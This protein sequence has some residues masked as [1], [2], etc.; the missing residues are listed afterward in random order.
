[1]AVRLGQ[2]ELRLTCCA[3]AVLG[4]LACA[5]E[6][7]SRAKPDTRRPPP[8]AVSAP[9]TSLWV[10]HEGETLA[11]LAR[12]SGASTGELARSNGIVD[13]NLII[14]GE[15]LR[16]P[17]GHH[18]EAR[19]AP[20]AAAPSHS[21]ARALLSQANASLEA[22]DFE[23]AS[24]LAARCVERLGG[25]PVEAKA[26]GLAARCHLVAGT[27]ATGLDRRDEAVEEFRR[28]LALDPNLELAP[29]STS[30]RVRELLEVARTSPLPEQP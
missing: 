12:C 10:V 25:A 5:S 22:A 14:A 29:D 24:A 21:A 20:A 3:A 4:L 16:L 6:P 2:Q 13:P 26:R 27:A 11:D 28:A 17:A 15:K 7:S 23:H 8:P 19:S 18:C 30:P 9:N 1:M